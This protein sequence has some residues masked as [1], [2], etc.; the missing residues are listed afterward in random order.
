MAER[1]GLSD[2][3]LRKICRRLDV[4]C[5]PA[6]WWAKHA[7]GHKVKALPLP[8][9]KPGT[10]NQATIAP[11]P[12]ETSGLRETIRARAEQVGEVAVGER[13]TDPIR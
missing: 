8:E 5:P 13:L 3:G 10:P 9:T 6:G 1:C 11:T 4:P 2:N 7:A 12:P